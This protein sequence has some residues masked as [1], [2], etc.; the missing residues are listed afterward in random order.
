[1]NRLRTRPAP[2]QVADTV[3]QDTIEKRP[4]FGA[5]T[6]GVIAR[7]FQHRILH[8]VQRIVG[9]AQRDLRHAK[10][11]ALD[12]GEKFIEFSRLLQNRSL[13]CWR[14]TI[15]YH[16]SV[17]SAYQSAACL[18]LRTSTEAVH[19]RYKRASAAAVD[20]RNAQDQRLTHI[21]RGFACNISA[22]S[23][24]TGD[25]EAFRNYIEL[26]RYIVDF[27]TVFR[28]IECVLET[29]RALRLHDPGFSTDLSTAFVDKKNRLILQGRARHS[30]APNVFDYPAARGPPRHPAR[31]DARRAGAGA[32]RPAA[33]DRHPGRHRAKFDGT[34]QPSSSRRWKCWTTRR[35]SI[36]SRFE[37]LRW[38]AE[39][40][41]HPIGEVSRRR[42]RRACARG[43]PADTVTN[44]GC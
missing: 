26:L 21:P 4:P 5:R 42:C 6:C 20:G 31:L 36:R 10:C 9:I 11:A 43:R 33:T 29:E 44:P 19:S 27:D 40:Y 3:F 38:A 14:G 7:Q 1:M 2:L 16:P 41:H 8:H 23:S 28:Q 24:R 34:P 15:P 39:Y 25:P 18:V 30:A 12:L 37:L 17:Q 22:R 35:Y 13:G 32:V